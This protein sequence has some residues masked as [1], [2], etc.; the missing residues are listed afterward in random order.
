VDRIHW[1]SRKR[2]RRWF[3]GWIDVLVSRL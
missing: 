1:Y 2:N 3:P